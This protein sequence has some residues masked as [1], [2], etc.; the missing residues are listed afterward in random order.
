MNKHILL[1][2][3]WLNNKES[4]SQE[5]LEKNEDEAFAA[6]NGSAS[7]VS[8]WVD[9]TASHW[10]VACEITAA[11]YWVDRYFKTTNEEKE[12]YLKELEK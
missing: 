9:C 8:C 6:V 4:V 2:M 12:E 11:T 1:V 10:A 7:Y 5:E 3:K